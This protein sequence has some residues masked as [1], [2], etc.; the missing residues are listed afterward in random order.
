[1]ALA[2]RV[3]AFLRERYDEDWWR[4][5]R[6]LPSLAGL[7]NRGG[8]PTLPELWSEMGGEPSLDFLVAGLTS[9]CR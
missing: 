9:A 8:R 4:N 2:A 1:M 7:W 5:P 6:S 3:R